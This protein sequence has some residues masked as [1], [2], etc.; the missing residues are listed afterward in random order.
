MFFLTGFS[1][2]AA[3]LA[4][5][6]IWKTWFDD[7]PA[8]AY[9]TEGCRP[10]YVWREAFPEDSVCVITEQA[11]QAKL[12]NAAADSRIDA[13]S[14]Y[15]PLGCLQGYVWRTANESDLVCV[16]PDVR[17]RVWEDNDTAEVRALPVSD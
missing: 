12:D 17:T 8:A 16:E 11:D 7:S 14:P 2:I 3:G 1:A 15:G 5:L 6:A 9:R 13:E 4:G 10:G